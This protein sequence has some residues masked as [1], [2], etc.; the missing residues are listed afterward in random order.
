MRV[1][2]RC[3]RAE[4]YE[5]S[6]FVTLSIECQE[7]LPEESGMLDRVFPNTR[8]AIEELLMK[9]ALLQS[10]IPTGE[11]HQLESDVNWKARRDNGKKKKAEADY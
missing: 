11:A 3:D 1:S 6:G 10:Y 8:W 7:M 2:I 5:E 9:E 4:V